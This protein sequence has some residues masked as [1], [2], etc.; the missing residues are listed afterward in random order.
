MS[1][2][3]DVAR[4][5]VQVRWAT[6]EALLGVTVEPGSSHEQVCEKGIRHLLLLYAL[7]P[8][9]VA[10]DGEQVSMLMHFLLIYERQIRDV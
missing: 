3:A 4:A 7:H 10:L 2:A 5:R 8:A 6:A 1:G 9:G